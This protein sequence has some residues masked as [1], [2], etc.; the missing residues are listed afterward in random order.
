M[1]RFEWTKSASCPNNATCVEV[2]D[3]GY[4]MHVRGS[5]DPDN[6]AL[7]FSYKE[8]KAFLAGVRNGEFDR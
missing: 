6:K 1:N 5:N 4:G 3:D 7:D 8:W 2:M